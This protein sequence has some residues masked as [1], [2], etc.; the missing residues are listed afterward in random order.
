MTTYWVT[1]KRSP[2]DS[3]SE[4]TLNPFQRSR[5]PLEILHP[6]SA[7]PSC[8]PSPT[9]THKNPQN[10]L[11]TPTT[12][13]LRV[14]SPGPDEWPQAERRLS[15]NEQ[16]RGRQRSSTL[17]S[18][19]VLGAESHRNRHGSIIPVCGPQVPTSRQAEVW[20]RS[21]INNDQPQLNSV[22]SMS[23][24][25][26]FQVRNS[27]TGA[28]PT[29]AEASTSQLAVFAALADDNARQARKLADW[30]AEL[31][32]AAVRS[33][34]GSLERNEPSFPSEGTS[35]DP[36]AER[37]DV[38]TVHEQSRAEERREH[39]STCGVM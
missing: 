38:E 19:S 28:L 5:Q 18:I 3:G 24:F 36:Q 15:R 4:E 20:S 23:E 7:P 22:R 13:P 25:N 27:I 26:I 35:V 29:I 39:G 12:R 9:S 33:R 34:E 14:S 6:T 17:P 32:R 10:F 21:R 31:A 16:E 11:M 1:G 8:P 37:E 2:D 30:A